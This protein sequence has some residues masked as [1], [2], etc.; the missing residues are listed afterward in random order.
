MAVIGIKAL[1]GMASRGTVRS[2][3]ST[4]GAFQDGASVQPAHSPPVAR[5]CRS[6]ASQISLDISVRASSR[7][8]ASQVIAFWI[9][10]SNLPW[11]NEWSLVVWVPLCFGVLRRCSVLQG[12]GVALC[13]CSFTTSSWPIFIRRF[14]SPSQLLSS[15]WVLRS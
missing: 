11:V 5:H 9:A 7:I 4:I 14:R 15:T 6:S 3:S 8:R 10:C 13:C 2:R 12:R 1:P